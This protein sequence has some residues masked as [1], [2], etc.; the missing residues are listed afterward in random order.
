MDLKTSEAN[1]M[2]IQTKSKPP[3]GFS[4][5]YNVKKEDHDKPLMNS[6]EFCSFRGLHLMAHIRTK[7]TGSRFFKCDQCLFKTSTQGSL[8]VHKDRKHSFKSKKCDICDFIAQSRYILK[9]H[10]RKTHENAIRFSCDE[11]KLSYS[12]KKSLKNHVLVRHRYVTQDCDICGYKA[13]D[14]SILKKHK[15]SEH[16][17]VRFLCDKCDFQFKGRGNLLNHVRI[18]HEGFRYSCEHCDY[19]VTQKRVLDKHRQINH[20]TEISLKNAEK[21]VF[22]NPD[23][24]NKNCIEITAKVKEKYSP[25]KNILEGEL[26]KVTVKE[27]DEDNVPKE[28]T[29][30]EKK[31]LKQEHVGFLTDTG[32]EPHQRQYLEN[33]C[34]RAIEK[35][36]KKEDILGASSENNDED[37]DYED[38][39]EDIDYENYPEDVNYENISQHISCSG[40]IENKE[41]IKNIN[42]LK[43]YIEN[44][45]KGNAGEKYPI[46]DIK[47]TN[48]IKKSLR[49]R[50]PS[51][52]C[53][54]C[55]FQCVEK[56][57]MVYHKDIH[58]EYE[59]FNCGQC[60]YW[61][62]YQSHIRDHKIMKHSGKRYGC[63]QCRY[64]ATCQSDLASHNLLV[65]NHEDNDIKYEEK[66][67]SYD[68][69]KKAHLKYEHI[70]YEDGEIV[71]SD[72][73]PK[74]KDKQKV[75]NQLTALKH[76]G[77]EKQLGEVIH[78]NSSRFLK[79]L[80]N[81][82]GH[83]GE[84]K[85]C[86]KCD[87]EF[88]YM[89]SISKHK[90]ANQANG[91]K[92]MYLK[93]KNKP[94]K[95]KHQ[96]S[97]CPYNTYNI[98]T[99]RIHEQ[100]LH[101]GYV[102]NCQDC[103]YKSSY[104]SEMKLHARKHDPKAIH[105]CCEKCEY[106]SLFK[107]N[108]KVHI[109]VKHE[110]KRH[111]CSECDAKFSVKSHLSQHKKS[112][113]EGLVISCKLCEFKATNISSMAYHK[114]TKHNQERLHCDQCDYKTLT[115]SNLKRHIRVCHEGFRQNCSQCKFQS[116]EKRGLRVHIMVKHEGYRFK[117]NICDFKT[118]RQA[119]VNLH[120]RSKHEGVR[121]YCDQCSMK[122]I[123][124]SNLREH[125]NT[126]HDGKG[127]DCDKCK[128]KASQHRYLLDHKESKHKDKRQIEDTLIKA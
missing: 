61:A 22:N 50:I 125:I 128:Y 79:T 58:H 2:G 45:G 75:S 102:L 70:E 108:L 100:A 109:E 115:N 40:E 113:H 107:R 9:N 73:Q 34:N 57:R 121:Y 93:K 112:I 117:C 104:L 66:Y 118:I 114:Q 90:L 56:S 29:N 42:T 80:H 51:F 111:S 48:Q 7:H 8:S 20:N 85:S 64:K 14:V 46:D 88:T 21:E 41:I 10:H 110:G 28:E 53:D 39:I 54:K 3:V 52:G 126:K 97:V 62:H 78:E 4:I 91:L 127:F 82:A 65:H 12:V 86:L 68:R 103:D 77:Y 26:E 95:D 84:W 96:C 71:E 59:I 47:I 1:R 44:D 19:K 43:P 17:G 81:N 99:L 74:H 72:E 38:I 36:S 67:E 55:D 25:K 87:F 13:L 15:D 49:S 18:K 94:L 92:S 60:D 24:I 76:W 27:F 69:I 23:T 89:K 98:D 37:A 35:I 30:L 120:T 6:C 5:T 105:Y 32:D 101:E 33:K 119:L 16:E 124:K 83:E 63:N 123:R 31:D 106:Q 11:C 116:R 122:F